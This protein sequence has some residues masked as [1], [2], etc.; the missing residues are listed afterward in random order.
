MPATM[1]QN[2]QDLSNEELHSRLLQYGMANMPVTT[3]TRNVLI[4]RLQH[5]IDTANTKN[6][7]ETVHVMKVSSGDESESDAIEVK[8][9]VTR[10]ATMVPKKATTP[11]RSIRA[12]ATP[13]PLSINASATP[14]PLSKRASATPPPVQPKGIVTRRLSGR[15][16]PQADTEVAAPTKL[17][18]SA[19][20][21][22]IEIDEDTDEDEDDDSNTDFEV[23]TYTSGRSPAVPVNAGRNT[24]STSYNTSYRQSDAYRRPTYASTS[25]VKS[26]SEYINED[27]AIEAPYLSDF[28]RRLSRLR[29]EPLLIPPID[30]DEPAQSYVYRRPS[31]RA[32]ER[33]DDSLWRSF[34]TMVNVFIRQYGYKIVLLL[35]VFFSIF[36]YVIFVKAD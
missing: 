21:P 17:P 11:P 12:S 29:A 34:V 25:T 10:R 3:T 5:F 15:I 28:T 14:L 16:T 30:D 22:I 4:K 31:G 1:D 32:A 24:I 9:K 8:K 33:R 6:R 26:S 13:P 20:M 23:Q 36:I 35:L 18:S 27:E 2:L 19:Q 7:R